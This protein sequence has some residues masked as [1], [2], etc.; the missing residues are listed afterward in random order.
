MPPRS[1]IEIYAE[2]LD[3]CRNGAITSVIIHGCNLKYPVFRESIDFLKSK[4]LI[5]E[6]DQKGKSIFVNTE[7]GNEAL[8][9]YAQY[10]LKLFKEPLRP[11]THRQTRVSSGT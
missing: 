5:K 6:V 1:R 4:D 9:S 3:C 10:Y 8:R 2:I 11:F 7:K